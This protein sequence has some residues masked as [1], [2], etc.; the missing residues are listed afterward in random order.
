MTAGRA[1]ARIGATH[2][3]MQRVRVLVAED[4]DLLREILSEGLSEEGFAVVLAM[5]GAQALELFGDGSA[6]DVLLLDEEMPRLTGR[7]L[8]ARL[9]AAGHAVPALLISGNLHLDPDECERLG[10]GPVLR[11]PMSIRSLA[12]ALREAARPPEPART[13]GGDTA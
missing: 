1:A 8:L 2:P 10:I 7:Q 13:R 6:Y 5:D 3:N 4:S 11:K 12:G 9:R